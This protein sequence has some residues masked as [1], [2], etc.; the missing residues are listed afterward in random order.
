MKGS[1]KRTVCIVTGTRAEY[2][3]LHRVI[4]HLKSSKFELKLVVTGS[5]LSKKYGLTYHEILKDGH[6]IADSLEQALALSDDDSEIIIH[7]DPVKA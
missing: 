6:E 2:G 4:E 5:H 7:I 3:L 1:D